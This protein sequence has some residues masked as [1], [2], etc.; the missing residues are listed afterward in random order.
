MSA[1]ASPC[2]AARPSAFL[3][4]GVV[5]AALTE[6]LAGTVLA[7]ARADMIGATHATPDAFA[8]LDVAYIALKLI[9]FLT[10]PWMMTRIAPRS[11]V[12]ASTLVMGT[13]CLAAGLTTDLALLT[14]LRAMQGL[15]GGV[16]LVGGQTVIFQT[17][18][19]EEQPLPQA[20][21]A[22]G[23]V[24][25]PVT[26][27]PILQGWLVDVHSWTWIFVS[28]FPLALAAAGFVLLSNAPPHETSGHTS[29]DWLGFSFIAT[30]SVCLTFVLS[31][32]SRWAWFDE[33]HIKWLTV[34]ALASFVAFLA[35]QAI[36]RTGTLV[37][38][39]VFQSANFCFA[40]AV[41]FV[42]GATLFGS[43]FLIPAFAAT[44][45]AFTPTETGLLL[46]PSG[47]FFI[48]A[49]GIAAFLFQ[50]RRVP[51]AAT[52]PFG[53]LAIMA[54]MWM[55][56]HATRESG[57]DDMMAAVLLRGVGLGFLFLSIVLIA[58][59]ALTNRNVASGIGLFNA[60]RQIGGLIGVAGLQTLID[61]SVAV[62]TAT[63]AAHITAGVPAVSARL[64]AATATLMEGGM[65][66][67][68]AGKVATAVLARSVATQ[69][70]VI[71]FD[72]A[73]GAIAVL[74]VIAAPALIALKL[75]L[76]KRAA[77]A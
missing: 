55:L 77:G 6:A 36:C 14:A 16:L 56:S 35:R 2:A 18:P 43:A 46:L 63:L 34:L 74:F 42:A 59:G 58:F 13:A 15:A 51:P 70:A 30:A 40:F 31:Q 65:E 4:T 28:T 52:V 44:V 1:I 76:A 38:S 7:V 33:G 62:N 53:I 27:A 11:L 32:G 68:A 60:G 45:L 21:F 66:A 39:S 26:I 19:P 48:G 3:L 37:D 73:F 8:G 5:F 61:H 20:I 17:Y 54:A 22:V 49:L 72:S 29:F 23:A 64:A 47:I 71:A 50:I 67:A 10:A 75:G 24:V 69:S 9:G 41:S 12:A 25:A 57:P